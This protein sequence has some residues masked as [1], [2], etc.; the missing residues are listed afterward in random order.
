LQTLA[1]VQEQ[2]LTSWVL[3]QEALGYRPTHSQIREIGS[4]IL[5]ISGTSTILGKRWMQGLLNR[6]PILKT[7]KQFTVDSVRVNEVG[8]LN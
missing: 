1:L 5:A 6:N 2:E 3:V 7:K 8:V 4:R